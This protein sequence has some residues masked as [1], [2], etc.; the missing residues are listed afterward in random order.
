MRGRA[1]KMQKVDRLSATVIPLE[2]GYC[3]VVLR[4]SLRNVRWSY[5]GGAAA[6][7]ATAVSGTVILAALHAFWPVLL[8]PV[9]G[10]AGFSW[11]IGRSY[12]PLTERTLLGLECALDQL[13]Q[14]DGPAVSRVST[15]QPGAISSVLQGIA[16]LIAG[17]PDTTRRPRE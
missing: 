3:Q 8:L 13:D 4:A 1:V 6:I 15:P 10:A 16:A 7:M 17:P 9:P 14:T 11:A 2:P 5:V 12:R